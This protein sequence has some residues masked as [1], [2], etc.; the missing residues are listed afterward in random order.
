MR[1]IRTQYD[2]Q[3]KSI[4]NDVLRMGALVEKSCWFAHQ[5]LFERNIAIMDQLSQQDKQIDGLYRQI[6]ID[7]LQLIALQSP[8]ATDLR[9]IGAL[10]QLIRDLERIGDYAEDLAECAIKLVPYDSPSYFSEIEQMFFATRSMLSLSLVALTDLD[11]EKGLH[12]KQRDDEVD[13]G[14]DRVYARLAN[15]KDIQGSAEPL[16]LLMLIIRS[17]ER[18]ADH[19]TNIGRRVAYIVTGQ[20]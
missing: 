5:S 9:L 2:R 8:V 15:E 6:E 19:A 18:M 20:R 10:M 1:P 3:V 12:I 4:Q 17:I 7:C 11:A 14:Y 13:D 16:L